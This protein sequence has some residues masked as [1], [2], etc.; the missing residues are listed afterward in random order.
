[1]GKIGLHKGQPVILALLWKQDGLTQKEIAESLG[2]RPP[3]LTVMLQ[4][5]EKAGFLKRMVDVRDM[6]MIRVSLTEKG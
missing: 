4:R 5:M 3:T 6:R 2:L 1:M